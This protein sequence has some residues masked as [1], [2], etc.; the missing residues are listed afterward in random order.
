[1]SNSRNKRKVGKRRLKRA[2][3]PRERQREP[4]AATDGRFVKLDVYREIRYITKRAQA[5]E[6]RLVVLGSLV[7]FSTQTRDA[8]LLDREDG[9]AVCLCRD[10]EP[11]PVPIIDSSTSFAI[12]WSAA[13]SIEGD[14]FIVRERSGRIVVIHDYP[15]SEISAACRN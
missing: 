8:W 6:A 9:F 15:T 1:M 11:Q 13:F 12:D 5:E 2:Q 14:A 4:S 7:L 10:G 3:R